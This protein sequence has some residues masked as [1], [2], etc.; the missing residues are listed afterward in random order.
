LQ[1]IGGI[2][3]MIIS[4]LTS[5]FVLASKDSFIPG[6]GLGSIGLALKMVAMQ[7]LEVNIFA[8]IISRIFK[9]HFDWSYQFISILGCL[10]LGWITHFLIIAL[11]NSNLPQIFVIGLAGVVYSFL[12][13]VLIFFRPQLAGITH[14][15]IKLFKDKLLRR[16]N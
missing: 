1:A 15:E 9:W 13:G 3:F 8:F 12:I 16:S 4:I 2:I 7:F 11:T 10:T 6:L 5:Y 14:D